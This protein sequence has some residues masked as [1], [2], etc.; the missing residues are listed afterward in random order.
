[1]RLFWNSTLISFQG[2]PPFE[3]PAIAKGITNFVA[4]KFGHLPQKDW[5]TMYD[6]VS[7]L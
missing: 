7:M 1:M 6:L 3:K 5:Q 2:T 4:Y